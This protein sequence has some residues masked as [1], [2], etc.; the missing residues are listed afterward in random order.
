METFYECYEKQWMKD[1]KA[2]GFDVQDIRIG[3]M[4]ARIAHCTKRLEKFVDGEIANIDELDNVQLDFFGNGTNYEK[5]DATVN[6]FKRIFTAN[7]L[8]W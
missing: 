6:S 5:R 4:I 8:S 1:N 7:I 3:G 2:V